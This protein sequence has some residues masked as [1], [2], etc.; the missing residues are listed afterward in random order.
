MCEITDPAIVALAEPGETPWEAPG[1]GFAWMQRECD[2]NGCDKGLLYAPVRFC[3]KCGGDG[4]LV[5]VV[6]L[7]TS[8]EGT[9]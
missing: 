6:Q 1:E 4:Y 5:R 9:D 2:G 7:P 3:C 8:T